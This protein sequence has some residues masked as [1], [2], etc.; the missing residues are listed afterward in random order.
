ML[1]KIYDAAKSNTSAVVDEGLRQYML[2][3]YNY[4]TGGL[5]A[6]ALAAYI[7]ANTS[8]IYWF[9]NESGKMSG[10]GWLVLFSP[11]IIIFGFNWVLQRGTFRQVQAT[12]WAFA[13]L[14]GMS[15]API[16]LAYT[17]ASLARVFLITAATFGAMSIYGYT[18]K[19]DLT[20][21]GS[22]LY[23]GLIGIIIA[24]IVNIFL[25]SSG[26]YYAISYIGVAIFVGLTAY[27]TQKIREIYSHS[28]NTDI[29]SRKAISGALELYLDFINLFMMLLRLLGDRK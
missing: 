27:D 18:T 28:D 26:L 22:F 13:I 10:L 9:F 8:M 16:V 1:D 14:M 21:M 19:K 3:V 5:V 25:Q 2:K 4:M 20:S 15:L 12:F 7:V 6:T 29:A 17:G 24:S 23:M 11:L